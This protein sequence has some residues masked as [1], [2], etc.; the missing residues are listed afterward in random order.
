MYLISTEGCKNADVHILIIKKTGE[1][2]PSMKGAGSGMGVKNISDLVLKEIYDIC[3]T[4]NPT[5]E[6]INEYKM[7]EREI[8][9]KFD[10]LS[11][12]E[13]NTKS[14]KNIY[15]RNDIMTTIIKRCR[16]KKKRHKS[17]RRI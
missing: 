17:N 16:G 15:V 11:K 3:E 14:Y 13:L 5:K 6:Q 7:T 10:N 2:W 1:I 9:E 8:Y 4:K 12:E